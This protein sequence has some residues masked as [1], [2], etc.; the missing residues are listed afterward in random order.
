MLCCKY[1]DLVMYESA[2]HFL[3]H[4]LKFD[5]RNEDRIADLYATTTQG[6]ALK[7]HLERLLA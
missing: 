3:V 4:A 1:R 6:R 7:L 2:S 5:Q